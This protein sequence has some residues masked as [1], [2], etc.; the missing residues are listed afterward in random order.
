MRQ[1]WDHH[2]R[3][4]RPD[5]EIRDHSQQET[6]YP[7]RPGRDDIDRVVVPTVEHDVGRLAPWHAD[8]AALKLVETALE[9]IHQPAFEEWRHRIAK[10]LAQP[11]VPDV[12]S[13]HGW[14]PTNLLRH[15]SD[16]S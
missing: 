2:H 16:G 11:E 7:E 8:P 9:P 1:W 13:R 3:S 10:P 12:A 15:T 14:F 6:R 4:A 5:E